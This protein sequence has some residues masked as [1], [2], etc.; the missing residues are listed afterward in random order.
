MTFSI[1]ILT[2]TQPTSWANIPLMLEK[3]NFNQFKIKEADNFLQNK[4]SMSSKQ[5]LTYTKLMPI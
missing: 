1:E 5:S 2:E 3:A 4:T